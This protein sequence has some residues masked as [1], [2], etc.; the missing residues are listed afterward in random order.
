MSDFL[1][2]ELDDRLEFGMAVIDDDVL[3]ENTSACDNQGNC[4]G[5]N[6]ATCNNSNNCDCP[7][8]KS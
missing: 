5:R 7:A 3:S 6:M 8:C 2:S 4:C 1:I